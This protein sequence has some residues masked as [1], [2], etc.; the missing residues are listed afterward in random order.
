MKQHFSARTWQEGEIIIA[1]YQADVE[2][3]RSD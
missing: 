3:L 2:E 1:Q